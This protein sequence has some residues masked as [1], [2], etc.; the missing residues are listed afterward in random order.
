MT[1]PRLDVLPP[2]PL[3]PRLVTQQLVDVNAVSQ[4]LI[5]LGVAGSVK[6]SDESKRESSPQQA[7]TSEI[8]RFDDELAQSL[9]SS[10]EREGVVLSERAPIIEQPEPV[11]PRLP[12]VQNVSTLGKSNFG[13]YLQQ[14][15][16]VSSRLLGFGSDSLNLTP[17]NQRYLRR[18][19]RRFDNDNDFVSILGCSNGVTRLRNG[20]ALLALGRAQRVQQVLLLNGVSPARI[21]VE[22]CWSGKRRT[23]NLP[24]RGV[25]VT[26]FEQASGG[27]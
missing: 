18:L 27:K 22:G 6:N 20:N 3:A 16:P 2:T 5:E 11:A 25:L 15:D 4:R 8:T 26:I 14:Y 1:D 19:A 10:L 23:D 21:L 9:L 17:A 13:E 7:S 12:P 24:N